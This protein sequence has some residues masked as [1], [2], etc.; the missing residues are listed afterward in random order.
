L[1]SN[2]EKLYVTRLERFIARIAKRILIDKIPLQAEFWLSKKWLDFSHRESGE[3]S[4][5][6]EGFK[7]GDKWQYAWFHLNGEIPSDWLDY[8]L[9][10]QLD[11][12]GEGLVFDSKG[13][14]IQGITNGSVFD[15][16]F[17]RDLVHLSSKTSLNKKID[18]WVQAVASSL[19]GLYTEPEPND[20]S[21]NRYGEY[22]AIVNKIRLCR[23]DK[24]HW[25]LWL[26]LKIL[27]GLIKTLAGSSVRRARIIANTNRAIDIYADN[28]ENVEICRRELKTS[29]SKL[30]ESSALN[31]TAVGHAHIDTAWLWPISE[32]IHKCARTFASQLKLIDEY[33]EYIFGASQPQHFQFVKDYYPEL[34]KRIKKAVGDGRWEVQGGMWVEADCNI[35]SGE[36]M[37]RQILFGKNFFRDEFGIKVDNLWLPDVFGYSANLPQILNKCGIEYFL[38]Q[39]LS[40]NQYNEFPYQTFIWRGIDGSEVLTHFP[41]ENT[42]NSQLGTDFLVPAQNSFKEKHFI[43]SFISLFGTGDGGGGPKEENIEL[44]KRMADLEGSPKVKFNTAKSL[45]EKLEQ[46][47]DALQNWVGEL[48]LELHRGTL[49]TQAFIKKANRLAEQ[50]LRLVEMLAS[51]LPIEEYPQVEINCIWKMILK[52]QFH[53]IIPGSSINQVYK[54]A[55]EEFDN[56]RQK[57][58]RLVS[59]ITEKLLIKDNK[60]LSVFNPLACEYNESLEL[61]ESWYGFSVTDESGDRV[62]IQVINM[63][64]HMQLSIPSLS[65]KTFTRGDKISVP[66]KKQDDFILENDLVCYRFDENGCLLS[67]FDKEIKTEFIAK[68]KSGNLFSLYEDNPNDWDAWDIDLFYEKSLA[69]YAKC[70]KSEAGETGDVCSWLE[71]SYEIGDSSISQIVML[72]NQ[73]RRLDFKTDVDWQ[74]KHRMLRVSFPTTIRSDQASYDIQYGFV[75]RPTHRNT[76]WDIARFEVAGHRYA[77]LSDN[78]KGIAL[79]ND[80]KYG[81][82]VYDNV[83]DLNLLRSPTYPDPDADIGRHEFTYSILPHDRPL[84]ESDVMDQAAQLNSQLLIADGYASNSLL[85]SVKFRGD[86]VNLEVVKRAEKDDSLVLRLVEFRGKHS[87]CSIS[88]DC[89]QYKINKTD[90]IEWQD[91]ELLAEN[92][93]VAL[94]LKPFEIVTLKLNYVR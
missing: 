53:D 66:E 22:T 65:F 45:F 73:N 38:T 34:Y 90:L 27:Q 74:E 85:Y 21:P 10:L 58:D 63:K 2:T 15:H 92:E 33:P 39:K 47:R 71:F 46:H 59:G 6:Q 11:F 49:T 80:C 86:G 78:D 35:I 91:G 57:L 5:V 77:D 26:D 42:Y 18:F 25:H 61:P 68:D 1:D 84:T 62:P 60:C 9:V 14:I 69:G 37:I 75:K 79:L 17:N 94:E 30:A 82:K 40:W 20:D 31:V 8:D 43:D 12:G 70:V 19:F 64:T 41:P 93:P 50:K 28:P 23:F 76:S 24:Q 7:W 16:E 3:Y 55:S 52:N 44:G 4:A 81:Y 72:N 87:S 88:F 83:L 29:L 56:C 32:T 67:A 54:T 13:H 51:M 36:S 89:P 48:Y